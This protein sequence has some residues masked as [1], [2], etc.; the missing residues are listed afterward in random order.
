MTDATIHTL[1]DFNRQRMGLELTKAAATQ[2]LRL[3]REATPK[4]CR[5]LYRGR[6]EFK[7]TPKAYRKLFPGKKGQYVWSWELR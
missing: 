6:I 4:A 3:A 5:K 1:R 2:E 7:P